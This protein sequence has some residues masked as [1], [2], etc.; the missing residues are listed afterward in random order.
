MTTMAEPQVEAASASQTVIELDKV[1]RWYGEVIGVNDVDVRIP[2]GVTGLLGPNGAGKTTLIR[3][4]TGQLQPSKGNVRV[5]G[6]PVWNNPELYRRVGLCPDLD[7]FYETMTG[8]EFVHYMGKLA[9]YSSEEARKRALE[10]LELVGLTYAKDKKVGA[11]SKGMRQR[12]KLAQALLHDPELVILDE[13][14]TGLDP[15]GRRE[16]IDLVAALG[17]QGKHILVSSHILHEVEAMTPRILLIHRGRIVAEGDV[18]HIRSLI[19]EHPHHIEIECS[20]AREL[21]R[22]LLEHRDVIRVAVADEESSLTVETHDPESFYG[23]I[24]ALALD[25]GIRIDKLTSPDD[26]LEAVFHYLVR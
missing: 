4:I 1:S 20:D 16:I 21:A 3:L 17:E 6:Q 18:Q 23:R 13:P 7:S 15:V 19:D 25:A 9:G 26:N 10:R 8:F 22:R 11:Y 2:T 14:L 5:L 24:S 12:T